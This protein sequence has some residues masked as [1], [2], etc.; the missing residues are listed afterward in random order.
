MLLKPKFRLVGSD[1]HWVKVVIHCGDVSI[2]GRSIRVSMYSVLKG[3]LLVI[4][5]QKTRTIR[6]EQEI[7]ELERKK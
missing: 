2:Y 7:Q 4:Q 3:S 1:I 6:Q 5:I